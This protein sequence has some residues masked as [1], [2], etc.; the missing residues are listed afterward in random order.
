[1]NFDEY[2]GKTLLASAGITTPEGRIATSAEQAARA[3]EELGA[4][5]IKAQVPTGKRG[6]AGGVH[7]AASP[8]AARAAAARILGMEIGGHRVERVLV[9]QRAAIAREFYAAIL[10]NPASKGPLVLFSTLGGMDI[11]EAASTQADTVRRTPVDI[12]VGFDED[13]ARVLV[14]GLTL[15]DAEPQVA[16]L[17]ARLYQAYRTNDAELLEINPLA[18]TDDAGLVALDCK[19][20]L[21]DSGAQRHPELAAQGVSDAT[22]ELER[23][24]R[25]LGLRYIELDGEVGVLANGAGL[26][27]TTLDVIARHS[28]RA[29]NFLEIGGD[30]YVK[31]EPALALVLANP[32]V[33]SLLINFCG[34]IARTDVMM[35]GVVAAWEALRPNV[36]AFFTIHGTGEDE[37]IQMLRERLGLEPFDALDDAVQ[38]AVEAAR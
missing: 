21:D 37:A 23:R 6:K 30:A 2:A 25:E 3:A 28:G 29:A 33:K 38:A 31:G 13:A 9:E 10:N 27:M 15:G 14:R 8:E 1:M 12:C 5:V 34:A 20:V 24:G 35:E 7:A 11:E 4:V 16:T 19:F 22:T 36:P 18:L 32:R 26:T 17:L